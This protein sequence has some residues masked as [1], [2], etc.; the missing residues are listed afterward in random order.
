VSATE[1]T[2]PKAVCETNFH[3]LVGNFDLIDGQL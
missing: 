3:G 1:A 2:L